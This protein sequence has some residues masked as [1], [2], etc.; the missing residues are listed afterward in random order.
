M[1]RFAKAWVDYGNFW[2]R[3]LRVMNGDVLVVI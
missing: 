1:G 2:G 3:R